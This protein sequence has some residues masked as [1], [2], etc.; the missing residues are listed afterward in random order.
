MRFLFHTVGR[1][2]PLVHLC[3]RGAVILH[4]ALSANFNI[5]FAASGSTQRPADSLA[6]VITR[7]RALPRVAHNL[8]FVSLFTTVNRHFSPD[9]ERIYI[10]R[11][12]DRKYKIAIFRYFP[13][14]LKSLITLCGTINWSEVCS[15][16][17]TI[18]QNVSLT[19]TRILLHDSDKRP[20][21]FAQVMSL[22][23]FFFFPHLIAMIVHICFKISGIN[24]KSYRVIGRKHYNA[25]SVL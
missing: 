3:K 24:R 25:S 6:V 4:E 5:V 22:S 21:I 7:A 20:E 11:K 13:T 8:R 16:D 15:H 17:K 10:S 14:R 2:V 23:C 19:E 1:H 12:Y 18:N 9:N